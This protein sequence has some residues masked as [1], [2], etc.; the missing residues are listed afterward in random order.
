MLARL[1]G[2]GVPAEAIS[3]IKSLGA[4]DVFEELARLGVSAR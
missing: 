2:G 1:T 4:L 3:P